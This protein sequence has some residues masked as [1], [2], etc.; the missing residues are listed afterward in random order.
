MQLFIEVNDPNV[1]FQNLKIVSDGI[2][3]QNCCKKEENK[4]VS[5]REY[6]KMRNAVADYGG[7]AEAREREGKGQEVKGRGKKRTREADREMAREDKKRE[8]TQK[9][10]TGAKPSK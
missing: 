1:I 7:A 4:E 10:K 6:A 3:E 5:F 2:Q 8:T 9:K